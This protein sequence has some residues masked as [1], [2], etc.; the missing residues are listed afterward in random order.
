MKWVKKART[1]KFQTALSTVYDVAGV[2]AGM[3]PAPHENT[4]SCTQLSII[5]SNHIQERTSDNTTKTGTFCTNNST[6]NTGS[7]Q[8]RTEYHNNEDPLTSNGSLTK[9]QSITGE[10]D[11]AGLQVKTCTTMLILLEQFK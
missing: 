10:S 8:K 11:K 6:D 2:T 9:F 7:P 5:A 4:S 3:P 1:Q